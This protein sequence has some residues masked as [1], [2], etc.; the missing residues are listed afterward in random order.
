[1]FATGYNTIGRISSYERDNQ[2]FIF[3]CG[4]SLIKIHFLTDRMFHL[5]MLHHNFS[6]ERSWAIVP[7]EWENIEPH[8]EEVE[9]L[10]LLKTRALRLAINKDPFRLVVEDLNGGVILED[11]EPAGVHWRGNRVISAKKMPSDEHYYGFGEKTGRLDKRGYHYVMRTRDSIFYQGKTDPLYQAIPFFV[12]VR[13]GR[14]YGIFLDN[15]WETFFDMGK[16]SNNIF[17]FGAEGGELNYYFFYGPD[18]K[19]VINQYTELTGKIPLPPVWSLGYHQSRWSYKSEEEV[20]KV[21]DELK[22]HEI[23]CDAI[24]LDIDY[25]DGFRVFTWDKKRFPNPRGLAEACRERGLRLCAII[26]PGVKVDENYDIF[27][28]GIEND[29]FIKRKDG[30]LFYGYVWP[31]KTVFPDFTREDVRK[32]WGNYVKSFQKDSGVSGL[33]NDM[34]EPSYNIKYPLRQVSVNG[35]IFYDNGLNTPFEKN[36][37][38]FGLLMAKATCEGLLEG[39]PNKRYFGVNP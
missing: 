18:I 13:R 32:W 37:N 10:F 7:K 20:L 5:S 19:E 24:S 39:E 35:L 26:D 25:M 8:L 21:A 11:T 23:P 4:E 28:E 36:R 12:G 29:Y 15:N 22:K 6:G 38:V 31:G 2:S 33:W 17:F 34:N 27:R 9:Y 16:K 30:T 1:M 3:N 14:C